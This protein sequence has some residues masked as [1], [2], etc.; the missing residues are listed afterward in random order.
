[1]ISAIPVARNFG[2]TVHHH[3]GGQDIGHEVVFFIKHFS[4]DDDGGVAVV[5]DVAGDTD[6]FSRL[7][8]ADEVHGH[9]YG[10][11]RSAYGG[12]GDA[13]DGIGQGGQ[14]TAVEAAPVV[15]VLHWICLQADSDAAAVDFINMDVEIVLHEPVL[16]VYIPDMLP[17]FLRILQRFHIII[18]HSGPILCFG[19]AVSFH[20]NWDGGRMQDGNGTQRGRG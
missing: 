6:R 9:G 16:L 10:D 18:D 14:D 3:H 17:Y 7:G 13:G 4:G 20:H 8:G 1:M 12:T 2:E 5:G 19:F 15:V 11:Y